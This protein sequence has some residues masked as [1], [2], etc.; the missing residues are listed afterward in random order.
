VPA[1]DLLHWRLLTIYK[2]QRYE[3]EVRLLIVRSLHDFTQQLQRVAAAR[4]DS[5]SY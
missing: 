4:R 2:V 3:G 5:G 1:Q